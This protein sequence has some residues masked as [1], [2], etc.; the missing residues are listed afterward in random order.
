M[1]NTDVSDEKDI[2]NLSIQHSID[3]LVVSGRIQL[4]WEAITVENFKTFRIER[5]YADSDPTIWESITEINDATATNYCDTIADDED[6]YYR[7]GVVDNDDNVK[8]AQNKIN[9]PSTTCLFVPLEYQ[10][11]QTV[12][13]NPLID[14]GDSILVAAGRY[15]GTLVLNGK[16]ILVKAS[17]GFELTSLYPTPAP[18]PD[19]SLRVITIGTGVLEGF[20]IINGAPSHA[21]PG[22]GAF[23]T[24][25][26]TIRNCY[27][28]E[29][30]SYGVGGGVFLTEQG[31][32]YNNIIYSNTASMD[33]RGLYA[34][35]AHGRVINNTFFLNNV[36]FAGDIDSLLVLNNIF[37][38]AVKPEARFE[39]ILSQIGFVLDYNR[40]SS[41]ANMGINN[42]DGE[43]QFIIDAGV[44]FHLRYSSPCIYAGHPAAEYNNKDGSRNTMG[45]YGGPFGE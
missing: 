27:I 25:T 12:I 21:N 38:D 9:L 8:W 3:R 22:G 26:G 6:L 28:T 7:V 10:Q 17:D 24:G 33:G 5:R 37:V 19:T 14:D 44:N 23:V 13:D 29:N 32:L 39:N 34:Q 30:N 43:P 16:N 41:I 4:E 18:R 20:T 15:F 35:N 36:V 45:A 11:I 31:N 42:I 1:F 2:F 40:I